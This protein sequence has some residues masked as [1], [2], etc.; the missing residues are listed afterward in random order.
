[1]SLLAQTLTETACTATLQSAAARDMLNARTFGGG[2]K[3][4]GVVRVR[5]KTARQ[6]SSATTIST[7]AVRMEFLKTLRA[8]S[9]RHYAKFQMDLKQTALTALHVFVVHSS[10]PAMAMAK[11][12][13]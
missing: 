4:A 1:V 2:K 5:I 11:A 7:S 6:D 9:K 10:V 3:T 8:V 13:V 12:Q